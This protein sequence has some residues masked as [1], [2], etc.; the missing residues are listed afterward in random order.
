VSRKIWQPCS[1]PGQI[2]TEGPEW[3]SFEELQKVDFSSKVKV[4]LLVWQSHAEYQFFGENKFLSWQY[5]IS[6]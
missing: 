4:K 1:S 3:T 2:W 6:E 5:F